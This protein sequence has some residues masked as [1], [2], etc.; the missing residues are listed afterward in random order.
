[1]ATR[2]LPSKKDPFRISSFALTSSTETTLKR[3]SQDATDVIG[4]TVSDSA[5][6]RALLRYVEQQPLSWVREQVYPYV[7]TEMNAGVMW[8]KKKS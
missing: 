8:G 3:I 6:V 7:G 4:R 5:V 2:K 1:M